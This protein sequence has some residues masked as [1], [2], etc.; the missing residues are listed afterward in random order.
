MNSKLKRFSWITIPVLSLVLVLCSQEKS[1]LK[2]FSFSTK[3]EVVEK[4][5]S[6]LDSALKL[7]QTLRNISSSISPSVVN[8]R[9]EKM[10]KT[11]S[12]AND[13]FNDPYFKK[14]FGDQFG[15]ND[16]QQ[17]QQALGTGIIISEDGYIISNNHVIAGADIITVYL[18][19]K[20]NFKGQVIGTDEKTDIAL[21]KIDPKDTKLP[22]APL[23]DSNDIQVGD[24]AIAIGNP[25]GLNWT[26]TFGV[27]SATGRT[28]AIDENAPYKSYIQTDVSINPGNSGGPLLNIK[29]Q[30][31][32]VNSAIYST[33]GGSIGIGFSIPINIVKNV[34]SQLIEKGKVE[35]GYIG[36]FIQ[37]LDEKLAKYYKL[38]KIEGVILTNLEKNGPAEKSGLKPGDVVLAVEGKK[39]E[40][41]SQLISMISN[42]PPGETLKFS[43]IRDGDKKEISVKIGLREQNVNGFQD[44]GK[45][46]LGM[47][48]GNLD[49]YREQFKIPKR[50]NRGIVI[51]DVKNES[52]AA[53]VGLQPGDLVDMINNESIGSLEE[54]SSFIAKNSKQKEFLL[55]VIRMNRIYF[56]VLE[57]K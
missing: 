19:D 5:S 4:D 6:S 9:T 3:N 36:A 11:Q 20:R 51:V 31:I 15:D 25:F 48:F 17:K 10:V 30:V 2:N 57:N 40:N 47:Q 1:F 41:T 49:S 46:W 29:G 54:F 16:Q 42:T 44:S 22:V 27:V 45:Y 18:S 38:S 35:R 13:Y 43:I 32:G 23:G 12:R 55:R 26:F 39:V 24:F 21:I 28:D 50:I 34:V 7:Q 52:V 8:I 56:I 53:E 14:F 37:D 33:T